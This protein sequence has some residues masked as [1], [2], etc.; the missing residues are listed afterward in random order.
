MDRLRR[1]SHD[2]LTFDVADAGDL[3]GRS[4]LLLHGFPQD[5]TAW[6]DVVPALHAVGLRTLAPD[7]RGYSPGARPRHRADYRLSLIAADCL[8][9]LDAAQVERAHVVGH[10]WGGA[11]A[12]VLAGR[13]A[14]RVASVTVLSTPHPAAM[15]RAFVTSTQALHSWYLAFAQLPWLPERVVGPRVEAMLRSTGLPT[16][17]ARY[18]AVRMREPGALSAALGWYRALPWSW[19]DPTPRCRVPATYVWGRR[20]IALGRAAAE[21]TAKLVVGPYRF[22][23]LDAGHW[24]PETRPVLVAGHV[25]ERVRSTSG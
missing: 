1:Y 14:E 8:A 5:R 21:A 18:Y 16:E 11:L 15:A 25:A 13:H 24:L 2:G 9:L 23:E 20:D 19:R 4:V 6:D 10:D 17:A 3:G 22:V 7:L 12:W